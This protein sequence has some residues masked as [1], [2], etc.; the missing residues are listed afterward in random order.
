MGQLTHDELDNVE[1]VLELEEND[2]FRRLFYLNRDIREQIR[3]PFIRIDQERT[4]YNVQCIPPSQFKNR[5]A[6]ILWDNINIHPNLRQ[7]VFKG[8]QLIDDKIQ[9]IVKISDSRDATFILIY[10]DSNERLP[11]NSMGDGMIHLFHIILGLVNARG[12]ILLIDEFENGLHYEV[13]QRIWELIFELATQLKIQVFATTHSNDTV[14]AFR[15]VASSIQDGPDTKYIKL[16][17]LHKA[18]TIKSVVLDIE[19]LAS[20]LDQKIEVR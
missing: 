11:L 15:K 20:I 1:L 8:L 16:K 9:E 19:R 4:K 5:D 2:N 18:E 13:Q 12:G 14:N 7:E 10:R 3:L 6:S 17:P